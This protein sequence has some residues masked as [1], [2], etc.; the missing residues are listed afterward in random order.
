LGV[1]FVIA[2]DCS[3]GFPISPSASLLLLP[4]GG[5]NT[6]VLAAWP[7]RCASEPARSRMAARLLLRTESESGF[8]EAYL[9]YYEQMPI[10]PEGL[11]LAYANILRPREGEEVAKCRVLM[12]AV[13]MERGQKPD[14]DSDR[15]TVRLRGS[16]GTGFRRGAGG[17]AAA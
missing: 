10:I 12:G 9:D 14:G 1:G 11:I 16:P 13:P 6:S 17:V 3:L 7:T 5:A 4:H 15:V 8:L 2:R